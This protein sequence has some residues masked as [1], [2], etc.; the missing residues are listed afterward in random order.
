MITVVF[1]LFGAIGAL[2]GYV[3]GLF[4][5]P[6]EDLGGLAGAIVGAI[7]GVIVV[8]VLFGGNSSTTAAHSQVLDYIETWQAL[9]AA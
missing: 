6:E 1:I 2:V 4:I 7:I 8:A 5:I 9:R 3:A